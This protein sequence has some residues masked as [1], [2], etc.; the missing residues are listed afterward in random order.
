M[1]QIAIGILITMVSGLVLA[2]FGAYSEIKSN[3]SAIQRDV[4][5][6]KE[7]IQEV[8]SDIVKRL[9]RIEYKID[10]HYAPKNR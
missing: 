3:Q 1:R 8:K 10:R 4:E 5:N 9:D 2:G 6:N 7:E